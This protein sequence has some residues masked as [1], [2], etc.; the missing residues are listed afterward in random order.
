MTMNI[1]CMHSL[2]KPIVAVNTL[3]GKKK[4]KYKCSIHYI[5]Y[6]LNNPNS[7]CSVYVWG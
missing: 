1:Y 4:F 7:V 5:Q 2:I 6:T 3:E